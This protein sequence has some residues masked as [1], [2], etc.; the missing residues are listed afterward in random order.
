MEHGGGSI[1]FCLSPSGTG[2]GFRQPGGFYEQLQKAELAQRKKENQ[3][4]EKLFYIS[5]T[6]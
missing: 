4:Q 6:S 2:G 5:V 1:L 3:C